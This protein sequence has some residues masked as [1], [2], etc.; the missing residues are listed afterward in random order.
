MTRRMGTAAMLVGASFVAL[1]ATSQR[2]DL[3]A[4]DIMEKNFFATKV[5]SLRVESTMVLIND[6]GEQR[7]RATS[8]VVK[9]QPNGVDSKLVVKFSSP[10]DIKGT[11][12]LQIEHGDSDDDRRQIDLPIVA[13]G[14]TVASG[15]AFAISLGE[16]GATVFLARPDRPTLPVAIFRFLGRP[17]ELNLATAYASDGVQSIFEGAYVL[18]PQTPGAWMHNAA[19]VMTSGKEDDVYNAPLMALIRDFVAA[20]LPA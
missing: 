20:H 13:R 1:S 18:V 9:L 16:F 19:G 14:L 15:F 12:V 7:Q 11:G 10:P 4:R 8:G 17:G 2:A 6:R 5:T 3:S